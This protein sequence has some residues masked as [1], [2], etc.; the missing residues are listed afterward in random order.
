VIEEQPRLWSPPRSV[1]QRRL[2]DT[3]RQDD[4]DGL[5]DKTW[6]VL[7]VSRIL[8]EQPISSFFRLSF[9]LGV[10]GVVRLPTF[11]TQDHADR[12]SYRTG[13]ARRVCRAIPLS[14]PWEWYGLLL[15]EGSSDF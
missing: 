13:R 10:Y 1:F 7:T 12:V 11:L 3:H 8:T 14:L 5:F 6:L 9:E 4:P 2:T 15:P